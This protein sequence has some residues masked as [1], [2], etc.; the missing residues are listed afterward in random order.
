MIK[1]TERDPNGI[2]FQLNTVKKIHFFSYPWHNWQ[3]NS[4]ILVGADKSLAL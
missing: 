1:K 3:I 4:G 2:I